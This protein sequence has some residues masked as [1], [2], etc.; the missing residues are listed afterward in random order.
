MKQDGL[1][2]VDLITVRYSRLLT[3]AQDK[4][5]NPNVIGSVENLQRYWKDVVCS[6]EFLERD[7]FFYIDEDY[8]STPDG[9]PHWGILDESGKSK[10]DL[11]CSNVPGIDGLVGNQG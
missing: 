4:Q 3:T 9:G 8:G 10:I 6:K 2:Y 1:R 5:Q 7:A 11:T